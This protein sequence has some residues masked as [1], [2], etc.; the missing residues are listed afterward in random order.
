MLTLQKTRNSEIISVP[1]FDRPIKDLLSKEWLL[2]NN[3]G[4]Y[5]SSTIIGCN[6]R[7]Y[8]G[9]LI[10]SLT[11]P[12]NRIMAL[13]NCLEMVIIN[14]NIF[15]LSTFEFYDKLTP[16]GFTFLKQFRQDTGVHFDY[17][18]GGLEL[19]KSVYLLRDSNT[20]AIT[21]D[22]TTVAEPTEFVLRPFIGLRDFHTLQ[23]SYA[24]LCS[25]R[26]DNS[27]IIRH[28]IADSCELFLGCPSMNF[29]EDHQWWF[30]FIYRNDR[31]RG[32]DFAEDLW[33][34]GFFKCRI[35]SPTK[36][37]FHC[38]LQASHSTSPAGESDIHQSIK[39]LLT[40]QRT[41]IAAARTRDRKFRTLCL[42]ADQ[43][44]ATRDIQKG[45]QSPERKRG[46]EKMHE[47][48]T[49]I[50]AGFPW[51]ADWGRDAFIA[52]PGL[53]LE[54]GR[55]DEAKSV[56]TTFAQ[57]ADDGMIPNRFDDYTN[58]A[59]FNSADASLWFIN[60]A[61]R[62]LDATGDLK[63]F[64]QKFLPTIRSIV[65]S[66]HKGTCFGICAD[67]D[68]L[69]T[70]GDSETQLTWMDT[71]Y[72]GVAFTP[73]YGKAVEINALWYNSLSLLAQFY[74]SHHKKK[75]TQYA[76]R[77]TQY[78]NMADKV[79]DSFRRLFWNESAG[80]LNDCILSA[81]SPA[82]PRRVEAGETSPFGGPDGTIDA[83]LR[84][85]Q[86]FAVSLPF[87]PLTPQQQVSVV[88]T[89]QQ[90][91]LT[92]YGLRTLAPSDS[93]YKGSYGGPQQQRDQAYHQ[94]TVWPYLIG[95][96]VEAYLKVNGFSRKSK[97][98]AADFIEPLMQHLTNE[99][100]LGQICEIFD[101]DPP[102][103]PKGCI[104]QAW[105]VAEL[106][107]AYRLIRH[108]ATSTNHSI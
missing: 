79:R 64:E 76:I 17:V 4:G 82:S 37:T 12:V 31:E 89:I 15:N 68:G 60:A 54:T 106:I 53:L 28:D 96:F 3:R 83:T 45:Q 27:L 38:T 50:L 75:S 8:H 97:G 71:K 34:P 102:H 99:G 6:T 80:C 47:R 48:Q 108:R 105:S 7:R 49:T 16:E 90:N 69:I 59:H 44:I 22:F 46:V 39:D 104:A 20:A 58:T 85:N 88:D 9:L 26:L 107:R 30:N 56:L 87:S 2:T 14:G 62:Y 91:L 55:F 101:G 73:R 74:L 84:P 94:G 42:A 24:R 72:N 95:P 10:G 25:Q 29:E 67:A 1:I 57:A 5:A 51:F 43:F 18:V 100:C 21:Y 77:H 36:I 40:H 41:V 13:A 92:P 78:E 61:F 63:T 70:A 23:K 65:D 103:K 11:P 81:F 19:T 86:I 32:Q 66:Y 52:L 93:R 98:Q 35:D 33:T